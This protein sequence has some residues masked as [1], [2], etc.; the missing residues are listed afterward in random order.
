MVRV[1]HRVSS[2]L[3]TKKGTGKGFQISYEGNYGIEAM[4][5]SMEMLSTAE[6]VAAAQKYGLEYNDKGYATDF[7]KEM[8]RSAL[9]AKPL[10]GFQRRQS[11]EQLPCLP[12]LYRP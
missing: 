11:A 6:Y 5:K 4:Y 7:H 8:T 1:E 10:C 3:P 2:R 12:R 9:G